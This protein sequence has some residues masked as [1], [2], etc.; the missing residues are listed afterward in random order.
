MAAGIFSFLLFF[1]LS[2]LLS[3]PLSL[4]H[5]FLTGVHESPSTLVEERG[6]EETHSQPFLMYDS[7]VRVK[8]IP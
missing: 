4:S 2:P 5:F 3:S 1:P 6:G 8:K 7:A